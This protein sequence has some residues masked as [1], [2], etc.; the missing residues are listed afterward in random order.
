[1]EKVPHEEDNSR[2]ASEEILRFYETRKVIT[3]TFSEDPALGPVLR[4]MNAVHN[5]ILYIL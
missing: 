5:L 4:Q 1:V 2:S 3:V